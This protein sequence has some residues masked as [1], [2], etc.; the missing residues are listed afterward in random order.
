MNSTRRRHRNSKR[1]EWARFVRLPDSDGC[2]TARVRLRAGGSRQMAA[3]SATLELTLA[4]QNSGQRLHLLPHDRGRE[5]ASKRPWQHATAASMLC[6]IYTRRETCMKVGTVPQ[7]A[8]ITTNAHECLI[9]G[10][11]KLRRCLRLVLYE[12]RGSGH[13][14]EMFK[15]TGM[16]LLTDPSGWFIDTSS[17]SISLRLYIALFLSRFAFPF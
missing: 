4:H 17:C 11:A 5:L 3:R 9:S 13:D 6:I 7:A 10:S 15:R 8:S 12:T 16:C 2:M 14:A 1:C